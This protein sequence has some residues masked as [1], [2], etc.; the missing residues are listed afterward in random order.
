MKDSAKF[1]HIG[2]SGET[3]I[4]RLEQ[5]LLPLDLVSDFA[6][7]EIVGENNVNQSFR[8]GDLWLRVRFPRLLDGGIVVALHAQGLSAALKSVFAEVV[9]LHDIAGLE[10]RFRLTIQE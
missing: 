3:Q 5:P 4:T 2:S 10:R 6:E 1:E 8:T 9:E 7:V